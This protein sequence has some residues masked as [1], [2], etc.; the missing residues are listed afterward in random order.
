MLSAREHDMNALRQIRRIDTTHITLELPQAFYG[1][2]VEIII[3]PLQ[4]DAL[5]PQKSMYGCA[6]QYANPALIPL[7][8]E[9]WANAA[10]ERYE[11]R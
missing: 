2:E 11:N 8:D 5:L 3:L 10:Q 7:E 1:Q 6:Q 9:A 4:N